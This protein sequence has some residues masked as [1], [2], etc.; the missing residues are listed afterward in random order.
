MNCFKY[1]S[2]FTL[3]FSF[4][5]MA[6]CDSR[7]ENAVIHVK[8]MKDGKPVTGDTVFMFWSNIDESLQLRKNAEGREVSDEFGLASFSFTK[9][10]FYGTETTLRRVFV[11]YQADSVTGRVAAK[12][13]KGHSK[14]VTLSQDSTA[15]I[16]PF[17]N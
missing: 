10:D 12:V 7:K 13:Q 4:V 3:L 1:L 17:G 5:L 16:W 11:T 15:I 9:D 8:V 6:G 14:D 2:V